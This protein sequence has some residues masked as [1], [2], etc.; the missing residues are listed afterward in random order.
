MARLRRMLLEFVML[1]ARVSR[2]FVEVLIER[3]A[4]GHRPLRALQL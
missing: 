2:S 3:W 4:T 1:Y